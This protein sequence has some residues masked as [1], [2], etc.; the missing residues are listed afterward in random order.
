[1]NILFINHRDPRHPSAGGAEEYLFQIARRLVKRGH[2]VTI[3][4]ER[5]PGTPHEEAMQGVKIIRKGGFATLHI[6]AL[7]HL[8]KHRDK[9]DAVVENIGHVF[10]FLTPLLRGDS[11]AIIHHVNGTYLFKIAPPPV[12]LA[13]LLAESTTPKIYRTI[14]T[15]SPSTRERLLALGAKNVNVAPPGVDHQIYKPGPKSPTP[16]IIWIN[17]FAPYKNPQDAV[18]IFAEVKKKVPETHFV[19][20]GG[21]PLL[22]KTE[23][24]AAKIAPF[25]QFTGRVP[26]H[27]K[28]KLL[29]QAWACLYTSDVEGFGLGILEAAACETP[30]VAYNVPGVRDA[31][32]HGTTG[33]LVP[34][35][36]TKTAAEALTEIIKNN[37]LR[38]ELA[39]AAHRHA[40][41]YNW[42]KTTDKIEKILTNHQPHR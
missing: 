9:Y 29:R 6:H 30:C 33:L 18:K 1:M 25:I 5:P 11:I 34:H 22:E 15:V 16:L 37:K 42:E 7:R 39:Q 41:Q 40:K 8:Q 24:I 17:R 12:A 35:R 21:G 36:D 4:A 32:I 38:Q 28:V 27:V 31:I 19:M 23:K 13:G 10:P 26:T 20:I 3:L 14:I 2:D